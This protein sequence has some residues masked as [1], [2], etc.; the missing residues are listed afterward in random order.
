[1]LHAQSKLVGGMT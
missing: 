1:M